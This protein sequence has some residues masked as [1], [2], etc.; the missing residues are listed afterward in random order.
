MPKRLTWSNDPR[1]RESAGAV[2]EQLGLP[3]SEPELWPE[4]DRGFVRRE[5]ERGF[6]RRDIERAWG[7][8]RQRKSRLPETEREERWLPKT[9]R[10]G[11]GE[12]RLWFKFGAK[13]FPPP[14]M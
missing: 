3:P 7:C 1:E 12:G 10:E 5:R 2:G 4:R 11:E 14:D 8:R 13:F 9:E 6:S